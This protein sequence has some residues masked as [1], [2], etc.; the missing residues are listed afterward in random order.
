MSAVALDDSRLKPSRIAELWRKAALF[1]TAYIF[2]AVVGDHLSARGS[3]FI[4][5]WL[6]AG[7]Y[8]AVLLLNPTRDWPWLALAIL[9][10]NLIF[11]FF[12]GQNSS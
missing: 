12:M 11:D 9:P 10:A 3:A 4:T 6:P 7:F 1:G 2:C 5:F 8:L